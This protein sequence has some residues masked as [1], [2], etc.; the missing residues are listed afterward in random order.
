[1]RDKDADLRDELRAHLDMSTAD[2]VARGATAEEAAAAARRELGNVSQ[3]HEAT[4]DVWGGRWL[5]ETVQDVRYAL[6]TFRRNPGFALVAILSLAL[7]IGANTALFEVVNAVR[8]RPLP[9]ANP[10]GLYEVRIVNMDG[11]RGNVQTWH[12][13]VTQPIWR[14]VQSRQQAFAGLFAWSRTA[15]NLAER[16]EVRLANGLWVSGEFFTTLGVQPALGRFLVPTDDAP[17]CALRAVLGHGFWRRNYGADP[18]VVGRT[19][20]LNSRPAEIVGVAPPG[21]HGLEV[22]RA[23]D[24][25]LPLCAEPALSDDGKGRL[26]AGTM[27]WL[28]IFGRLKPGWTIERATAHL[29]AISPEVFRASLPAYYPSASVQGYLAFKLGA[30]PGGSGLSLLRESYSEPLW[31]LLAIAGVVLVIACANLANLLLARASARER[32]IAVRLGLGASRSRLIRQLLTESLVLVAI[33]TAGAVLLAGT[34][35][36]W[37]VAALETSNS[38]ITLSLAMDWTV[39]GFAFGLAVLTCLLFGLAPAIRATRVRAGAVMRAGTRG[40]AGRDSV[41]MRRTLVVVQIALSVALLFGSLLF[42]RTLR[43]VLSVDP[44]FQVEGLFVA[45]LNFRDVNQSQDQRGV[46]QALTLERI[47]AIPGIQAVGTVAVVPFSGSSGAN[48]VWPEQDPGHRF[49]S[50]IN[51]VGPGFFHTLGVPLLA[52]RDFDR[53]DTPTSPTVAIVNEAFAANLGGARGAVGKRFTREPT[54]RQPEETYEIVGVVG[55]STYEELKEDL[56]PV[57][58]YSDTQDEPGR[59]LQAVARTT[60]PPSAAT[61]AVTSVLGNTDPRIKVRYA[62]LP[63]MM[64][65]TLVQDRLLASLSAGFAALAAL[66]TVI[67]LYGLISYTVSRRAGEIG[68]R[69]A[70]GA[71]A[72]DIAMLLVRETGVLISIGAVC[73][74]GLALGGAR[75]AATLLFGVRPYDPVTLGVAVVLLLGIAALATFGPARRA[76]RINPVTALRLD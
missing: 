11:A 18:S 48:D 15:F 63:T 5:R 16:G 50:R 65:D 28:S 47:K 61:A 68:I 38:P 2:R 60:L 55:N 6:R 10:A 30:Y 42:A 69:M 32:E 52:G 9:I 45:Q 53:R 3:I 43:N 76:T 49:N 54:P 31:L 58:Y 41:A 36:Q 20:Q 39:I 13:S 17:G 56:R 29:A 14:Q 51:I 22:G 74:I 34:L 25:A 59:Y 21:F 23:F 24:V 37:L 40:S 4:L 75:A 57:A 27:W 67:G 8:L 71:K 64:S 66:L 1:M 72:R 26:E 12:P 7:G 73:G 46:L 44:G 19:I 62:I 33:G 70:L 35:G